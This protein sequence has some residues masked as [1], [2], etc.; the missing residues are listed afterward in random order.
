MNP[1]RLLKHFEQISEAPDAVPRLRRF[2][3]DLAVRGKLVE[4]NPTDE[5]VS[6]LLKR[7]DAEKKRLLKLKKIKT[8]DSLNPINGDEV[9]F[10]VPN[11]WALVRLSSVGVL[12]GG[13]TPSKNRAAYWG[14][15]INWFSPKDIKSDEL[16][17][18]E[19][20]ITTVGLTETGLQLYPAG[21]LFIVAR[22]GILKRTFPV[23]INRVPAAANQDMKVLKP[24]VAKLDRYLQIM[25]R[26]M[27]S[28]ILSALVK[29]G[30]TVQSLKYEKFEFQPIPLPPLAE[31]HRIVAKVDDLMT[32]CDK[33][34]S[35]QARREKRR[36]RLVAATLHGLNKGN[37]NPA[38]STRRTFK[39]SA[40]F[41]LNHLSRLT[42][43]P[44]HIHQLRQTIL[45]LAVRGKL[46]LQIPEEGLG[47]DLLEATRKIKEKLIQER[48]VRREKEVE[49]STP[50]DGANIPSS[51]AWAHVGDVAIVQGGKRL[52][53]GVAFSE[54]PTPYIYIRITNMKNGTV[55]TDDLMYITAEVQSSIA[56]Y[57]INK[58]DLY[59]TIA[60]TIGQVGCVPAFFDGQNLTEN[61]AK[62]V[63]R[64]LSPEYLR[65]SLCSDLV[66]QQFRDKTKQMAQP[67]LA[68]KRIAGA[69]FPLP[70][71]REQHRIVAKVGELMALCDKLEA[72][73]TTNAAARNQLL[74]ATLQERLI[75]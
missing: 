11:H 55:L 72:W 27:T 65:L 49:Y 2:I 40:R 59:I 30:T 60:G 26:G 47:S 74:E 10:E 54:L 38:P 75:S 12:S 61:A 32:L 73:L 57:T 35:A 62:I 31:Q 71:I 5:P 51:W 18:S 17:D 7:I 58:E 44:E 68:L 53:K 46:V 28:F 41:Y 16:L 56:Q 8:R 29:T 22:S 50:I 19:L 34:E 33:L 64:G 45:N 15:E 21:C 42:T 43:R 3:L 37:A 39:D 20:K 13:M 9:P 48:G 23:A 52:P 66:Q 25:F 4:K 14:G 70:P 36:D 24:F 63:F 69:R 1:E 6:D 67:K